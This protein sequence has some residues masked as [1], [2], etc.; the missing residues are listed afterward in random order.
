M[1]GILKSV[2]LK[3][4]EAKDTKKKFK[5]LVFKVDVLMNDKD[6]SVKTYTGS[7]GEQFARDYFAFCNVKTK[8]LIG[9]EVGVVLA[10]KQM[11]TAEGETRVIQYVKYLNVL[12]AEGK[13]IVYNKDTKQELDF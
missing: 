6:K 3:E 11:T 4:F 10:K 8:D 2:E 13:E 5:K 1:K 9:K 7:Y 12:D